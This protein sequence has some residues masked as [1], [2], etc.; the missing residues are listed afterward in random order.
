MD[1]AFPKDAFEVI[2]VD[3]NSTDNTR[4]TVN[5]LSVST[6]VAMRYV[7]EG[8]QGLSFARNRGFIESVGEIVL[9]S[10]D[11]IDA[12]RNWL[13]GMVEAFESSDVVAAGGP[14]KPLWEADR[15]AWLPD[16]MLDYLG[17]S[18]FS[19]A[20]QKG[21]F[22]APNAPFGVN[23][24]FRREVL[25][26]FG[27]FPTALGRI[28]N[29]LLSN[30]EIELFQRIQASGLKI[31]FAANA[32][33]RHKIDP[34]RLTKKWF[35][36][37][38]YWQGRSDAVLDRNLERDVLEK[39]RAMLPQFFEMRRNTN[40]LS[41][42]ERFNYFWLLGYLHQLVFSE[43]NGDWHQMRALEKVLSYAASLP[44]PEVPSVLEEQLSLRVQALTNSLSWK[45]TA[46]LRAVK[47]AIDCVLYKFRS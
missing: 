26:Q 38:H 13:R 25:Q 15:P 7:F 17:V 32:V 28:G 45:V 43:G 18:N 8:R 37:R 1:Q 10:D 16:R 11:D 2:V 22:I 6:P 24:A 33:I 3:N 29:R 14:I 42:E 40:S 44:K 23:M 35:Y 20:E 27:M 47:Q 34:R 9:F 12:D 19:S 4:Q 36:R 5:A 41:F 39:A 31:H 30:E 46:P 21:E